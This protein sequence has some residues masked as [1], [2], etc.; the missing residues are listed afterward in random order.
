MIVNKVFLDTNILV[1]LYSDFEP[2]KQKIAYK[3]IENN[4]RN[5]STQVL[6]EFCQICIKKLKLTTTN[7]DKALSVL[8][9]MC[10]LAIVDDS[11]LRQALLI[12]NKYKYTYYDSLIIYSAL[13][14][15][16]DYLYTE[17]M[18]DGQVIENRLIIKDIFKK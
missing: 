3:E 2:D 15:G 5:I 4:I 14:S 17:D 9:D 13:A 1:Y 16:C 8:L 7:I 18:Q 10:G 6:T 11:A 12:Q